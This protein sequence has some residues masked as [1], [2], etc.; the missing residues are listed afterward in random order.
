MSLAGPVAVG[1]SFGM[2]FRACPPH[3]GFHVNTR[4][5][6]SQR[7]T[8]CEAS[9]KPVHTQAYST[10]Q[11]SQ[12]Y[13]LPAI[14]TKTGRHSGTIFVSSYRVAC[15]PCDVAIIIPT[16][17]SDTTMFSEISHLCFDS[18]S[19]DMCKVFLFLIR[20]TTSHNR[21]TIFIIFM[22]FCIY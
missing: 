3:R 14:S 7:A 12:R 20:G 2:R 4:E 13:D 21:F 10:R 17:R 11:S 18:V 19:D 8:N 9:A 16:C 15:T 1:R 5:A 22:T 6:S